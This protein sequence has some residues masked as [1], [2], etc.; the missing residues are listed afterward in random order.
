MILTVKKSFFIYMFG[1]VNSHNR[2]K[3]LILNCFLLTNIQ[4]FATEGF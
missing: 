3:Y 1:N 4:D 2:D